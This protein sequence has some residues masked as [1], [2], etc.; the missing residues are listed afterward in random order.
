[1]RVIYLDQNILS[2]LVRPEKHPQTEELRE[3]MRLLLER[4]DAREITCP[5][6]PAQLEEIA[7]DQDP[8]RSAQKTSLLE[9]VS[10][11]MSF[12]PTKHV[13]TAQ[14]RALFRN[15]AADCS[16][17]FD[18]FAKCLV[19]IDDLIRSGR[20]TT[21]EAKSIFRAHALKWVAQPR[22]KRAAIEKDESRAYF[23]VLW[24][25]AIN[26]L[27]GN[28]SIDSH[29][30]MVE[31]AP[32]AL[33]S[34]LAEL[35]AEARHPDPMGA[36][37]DFIEHRAHE[38]PS[39]R[40]EAKLWSHYRVNLQA[41]AQVAEDLDHT[42]RDIEAAAY[43]FPYCDAAFQDRALLGLCKQAD[44]P[45]HRSV[46]RFRCSEIAKFNNWLLSTDSH[47][48]QKQKAPGP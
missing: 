34:E 26:D 4:A 46:V 13:L 23:R 10:G 17:R 22:P 1:M 29:V 48:Q 28:T 14:A 40:I 12:R 43:W 37:L 16:E 33:V 3:M 39:I 36:A 5:V 6:S 9:R 7:N 8:Q 32:V 18:G 15:K 47:Q 2:A 27:Q 24:Q 38:L 31:S 42:A 41:Q 44:D 45:A 35:Y 11:G 30:R 21:H 20:A 25:H 19:R